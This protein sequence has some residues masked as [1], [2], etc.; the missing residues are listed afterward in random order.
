[1]MDAIVPYNNS[2]RGMSIEDVASVVDIAR[3]VFSSGRSAISGYNS[4]RDSHP[5]R[6]VTPK[7]IRPIPHQRQSAADYPDR[8]RVDVRRRL[9][10]PVQGA[11]TSQAGYPTRAWL[12][13]FLKRRKI[14]W[15]KPRKRSFKR[16]R[17][18][19]ISRKRRTRRGKSYLKR[20]T[21]RGR[22]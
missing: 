20:T 4:F 15:S 14:D 9:A 18:N 17:G 10:Y 12:N 22:R 16:N 11:V 1:M 19:T 5:H 13:R 8:M 2:N 21:T 7:P 6:F 3:S